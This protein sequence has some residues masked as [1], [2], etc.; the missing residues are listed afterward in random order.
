MLYSTHQGCCYLGDQFLY[1]HTE[2]PVKNI[3]EINIINFLL[4]REKYR[5]TII[6]GHE[7]CSLLTVICVGQSIMFI[8]IHILSYKLFIYFK[9]CLKCSVRKSLMFIYIHILSY[10][11]L[12]LYFKLCPSVMLDGHPCSFLTL[13]C[14][15]GQSLIFIYIHINI[16]SHSLNSMDSGSFRRSKGFKW[17]YLRTEPRLFCKNINLFWCGISIYHR[18]CLISWFFLSFNLYTV[19]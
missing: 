14:N 9:L 16:L 7:L 11:K 8:Y 19:W 13:S 10:Y 17:S 1:I 5:S 2:Y 4:Q 6:L 18:C 15:V 3:F 12:F